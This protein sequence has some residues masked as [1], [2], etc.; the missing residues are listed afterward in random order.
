MKQFKEVGDYE[1]IRE[2]NKDIPEFLV[3]LDNLI[4]ISPN[5]GDP[6]PTPNNNLLISFCIMENE[7]FMGYWDRVRDRLYK[8]RHSLNI[9]GV[10]RSL[11]LFESPISPTALVA[12]AAGGRDISSL[13]IVIP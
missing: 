7:Q 4:N 5:L 3:E 9:E 10:F 2:E 6:A 13:I 1:T 12:A 11:A 8:I